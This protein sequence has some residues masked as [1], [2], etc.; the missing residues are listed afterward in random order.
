MPVQ[1]RRVYDPAESSEGHRYLIDRLWPRGLTTGA[2]GSAVWAKELAPSPELRE[3]YGHDTA[4]YSAFRTRYRQE[5][6]AHQGLVDRLVEEARRGTVTLLFAARDVEH[7]N[8]SVLREMIEERVREAAPP[9]RR[10]TRRPD[11]GDPRH[12]RVPGGSAP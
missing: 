4:R 5:L 3:W 6:T 2:L 8:A 7:S 12:R 11:R 9:P 1:T 10:R